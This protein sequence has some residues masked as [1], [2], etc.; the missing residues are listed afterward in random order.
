MYVEA[1]CPLCLATHIV[2]ADRR[3][4]R[5]RC[6]ECEEVFIVNKRSKKTNRRP[7]RMRKVRAADDLEEVAA[8][9]KPAVLPV[10]T[11][12]PSRRRSRGDDDDRP[13]K[14]PPRRAARPALA[15]GQLGRPAGRRDLGGRRRR[16]V[17][18][19]GPGRQGHVPG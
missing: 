2:P 15:R 1:I 7:P 19:L 3:G 13:R 17:G 12:G 5:Y 18:L 14:R 9:D 11:A 8:A 16:L 10:A 4:T 6:E